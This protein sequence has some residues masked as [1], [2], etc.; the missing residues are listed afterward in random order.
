MSTGPTSLRR[1]A[2]TMVRCPHRF[3]TVALTPPNQEIPLDLLSA[4]FAV[5]NLYLYSNNITG[6]HMRSRN[7][8]Y[9]QYLRRPEFATTQLLLRC[10]A[11]IPSVLSPSRRVHP[12]QL[13]QRPRWHAEQHCDRVH[14]P[15][16]QQHRRHHPA[17]DRPRQRV[18][19]DL[20]QSFPRGR[21]PVGLHRLGGQLRV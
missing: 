3:P 19:V 8:I 10:S 7:E 12:E 16:R 13:W 5:N 11:D 2:L 1:R 14:R 18:R 15:L 4:L 21:G 20:V 9:A 17:L 6:A